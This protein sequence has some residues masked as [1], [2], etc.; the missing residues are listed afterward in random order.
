MHPDVN[1]T[2]ITG[3]NTKI[4]SRQSISL[5]TVLHSFGGLSLRSTVLLHLY[6]VSFPLSCL[7]I[8]EFVNLFMDFLLITKT[9]HFV[10]HII[11]FVVYWI[12]QQWK[13]LVTQILAQINRCKSACCIPNAFII[14]YSWL[15]YWIFQSSHTHTNYTM[16][17]HN[18]IFLVYILS[19]IE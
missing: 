19:L 3:M 9:E 7:C 1:H 17:M 6:T 11:V 16:K 8:F 15:R 18:L 10:Y 14:R 2:Q 12:R 13:S 4:I 5:N